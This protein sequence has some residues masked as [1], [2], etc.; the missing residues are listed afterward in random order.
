MGPPPVPVCS[1]SNTEPAPHL[2]HG[3]S[4]VPLRQVWE[5]L[6]RGGSLAWGDDMVQQEAFSPSGTVPAGPS[7]CLSHHWMPL[8][9]SSAVHKGANPV[10]CVTTASLSLSSV[11]VA[12]GK[13]LNLLGV[14]VDP[15]PPLAE[16]NG[17]LLAASWLGFPPRPLKKPPPLPAFPD[18]NTLPLE[19]DDCWKTKGTGSWE[20]ERPR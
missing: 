19:E 4:W 10:A 15:K 2:P 20:D 11:D 5:G 17:F 6:V 7:I 18:P 1:Q 14:A 13:F 9:L 3:G 16:L 8:P 12:P